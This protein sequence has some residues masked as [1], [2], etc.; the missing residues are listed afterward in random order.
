MVFE[1]LKSRGELLKFLFCCGLVE[2]RI[3]SAYKS[4]A[5]RIDDESVKLLLEY[6]SDD[7]LKHSRILTGI[8]RHFGVEHVDLDECSRIVGSVALH[9]IE[10][11]ERIASGTD[12]I[13][14][15]KLSSKFDDLVDLEK[16]FGEE[17]FNMIQLKLLEVIIEQEKIE[18]GFLKE[19]LEYITEDERR[20]EKILKTIKSYSSQKR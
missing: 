3:S 13:T 15:D 10:D 17:Y 8:A 18:V 4:L 16:Y 11:A 12:R 2:E 1:G 6:I 20:H 9:I 5:S 14:V 19:I 7:S